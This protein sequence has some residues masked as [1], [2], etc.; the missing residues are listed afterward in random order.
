ML[1]E[2]KQ[3]GNKDGRLSDKDEF[4]ILLQV[5]YITLRIMVNGTIKVNSVFFKN[6][7]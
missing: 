7:F 5:I 3:G 6:R 4:L 1:F 2:N